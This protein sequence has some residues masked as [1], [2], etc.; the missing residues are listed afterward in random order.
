[1]R[2][3][4]ITVQFGA[5]LTLCLTVAA[6]G[7]G[8]E[9]KLRTGKKDTRYLFYLHGRI[10]EDM[11]ERPKSARYGYYEYRKILKA[12][13]DKG[14]A[15]KSEIRPK[16][17]DA[18]LYAEKIAGEIRELQ[19]Q[20]VPSSR[21][22]VVGASKGGA[23]AVHVSGLLRDSKLNFVILAGLFRPL[24]DDPSLQLYGNVLSIHDD[25]DTFPIV[26]VAFFERSRNLGRHRAIVTHTGLGHGLLYRPCEEWVEP[27]V[28]WARGEK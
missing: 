5:A 2:T 12:L 1:M 14:F 18:K 26:P 11:G 20:G 13:A 21:I 16:N 25:A 23:I 6:A 8:T 10:V 9:G 27:L 19:K 15:V 24:L 4:R 17:T 22:T 28:S 3:V 7:W